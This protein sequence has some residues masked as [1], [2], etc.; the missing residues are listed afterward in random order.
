MVALPHFKLIGMSATGIKPTLLA[1]ID[2][3]CHWRFVKQ[4][5]LRTRV[6]VE[7]LTRLYLKDGLSTTQ[8]A[9]RL[10]SNRESVRRLMK[11]WQI[12][13]RAQGYPFDKRR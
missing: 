8:I 2:T 10:G 5:P 11:Q 3:E 1:A 13:L 12:P 6:T 4:A 9:N 7:Q